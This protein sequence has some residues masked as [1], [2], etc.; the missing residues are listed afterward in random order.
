MVLVISPNH[1][2]ARISRQPQVLEHL[3]SGYRIIEGSTAD[4]DYQQ[5]SQDIDADVAFAACDFL[6]AILAALAAL[7]GRLHRLAVDARGTGG[8][9]V[10]G[11]L[12]LA[13]C[14]A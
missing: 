8:G 7:F 2:Q 14:G 10:R 11:C 12:L 6:A 4:E 1:F 13:D 9:L 3:R 5:Q